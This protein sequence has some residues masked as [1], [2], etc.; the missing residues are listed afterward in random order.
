MSTQSDIQT[1][2]HF[3]GN[4]PIQSKSLFLAFS[5]FVQNLI[6]VLSQTLHRFQGCLSQLVVL[7]DF[8]ADLYKAEKYS[9]VSACLLI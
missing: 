1:R 6:F 4:H 5:V 9:P 2:L 8:L 7:S 3:A